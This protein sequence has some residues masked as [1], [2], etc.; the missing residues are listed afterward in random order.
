[1]RSAR[2]R[3]IPRACGQRLAKEAGLFFIMEKRA[4]ELRVPPDRCD[5][6]PMSRRERF[7]NALCAI[8]GSAML[9]GSL[10]HRLRLTTA[11]NTIC[12]P[13]PRLSMHT[14]HAEIGSS[15]LSGRRKVR[16]K[17]PAT[18]SMRH[19]RFFRPSGR[20]SLLPEDMAWFPLWCRAS[21]LPRTVL[22]QRS[23]K[24]RACRDGV[25]CPLPCSRPM[26]RPIRITSC[27]RSSALLSIEPA[28]AARLD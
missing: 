27:R 19:F 1:M 18:P 22:T 11:T 5:L 14:Y 2:Q 10:L 7:A 12:A 21:C 23:P 16:R 4:P 20:A 6:L 15:S 13:L 9:E 25:R 17:R 24:A 8:S 3:S 26:L 28:E